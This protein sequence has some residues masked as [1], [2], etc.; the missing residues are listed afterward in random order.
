VAL[1]ATISVVIET[2]AALESQFRFE[3]HILS[4]RLAG[5]YFAM[6]PRRSGTGVTD[7]PRATT[8]SFANTWR[9]GSDAAGALGH[10]DPRSKPPLAKRLR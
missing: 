7:E 2:G 4:P 5:G 1:T 8:Y 6:A 9:L 10:L 3:G